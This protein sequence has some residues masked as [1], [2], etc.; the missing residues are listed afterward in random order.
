[1]CSLCRLPVAKNHDLGKFWLL[2]LLYRPPFTDER[3]ICCAIA[4]SWYTLTCELLS[5]SVYSVALCWRKTPFLRFFR[6]RHLVMSP[7]GI[8]LRKL[9]MGVQLQSFPYPTVSKS[10]LYSSALMAKVETVS[11]AEPLQN[12]QH[13][14][15]AQTLTFKSVTDRQTNRQKTQRFWPPR[16]RV[17]SESYQTWH[18]D[19]GPRACSCT[20]KTFRGLTHI[21]AA[22]GRWKF[23]DNQT[24]SS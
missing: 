15:G 24:L 18:G 19:R 21:F 16:Q 5:R 10:F 14:P 20:L 12:R 13:A 17:K 23:G 7:I 6:L 11:I 22:R 9:N 8:N 3:Q 4:D 2:G 1:M